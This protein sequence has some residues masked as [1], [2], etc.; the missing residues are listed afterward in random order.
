[1]P[2]MYRG[3]KL[4]P[5]PFVT[6]TKEFQR[7]ED[8]KV[9]KTFFNITATSKML[10]YKGGAD[11]QQ[12]GYPPDTD[13]VTAA[14]P[15]KRLALIIDKQKDMIDL[16]SV[17]GGWFEIQPYDGSAAIRFQPRIQNINFNEGLWF[18]Y[19]PYT[20]SMQA[21]CVAFG[22]YLDCGNNSNKQADETWSIEQADERGRT[23]RMT[24]QV[25][26][27]QKDK[28]KTD[29]SGQIELKGW[30]VAREMVL[31]RLGLVTEIKNA[32]KVL[33]LQNFNAY[34]YARSENIDE[35]A[36]RFSVT[37]TWLLVNRSENDCIEEY[38][39]TSRTSSDTGLT[40]V[41]IDGTVTGLE[42]RNN[43]TRALTTERYTTANLAFTGI[44]AQALSRCQNYSGVTLNPAPLNQSVGRQPL[45]GVITYNYEYNN[46]ASVIKGALNA[47]ITIADRFPADV[48]AKINVLERPLGPILQDIGSKTEAGRSLTIDLTM[49][50]AK[51]GMSDPEE[52]EVEDL[53][54]QYTP[55][56]TGKV[57]M[58]RTE[59]SWSPQTGRYSRN[60]SWTFN[61]E[62]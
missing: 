2:V 27:T 53:V 4:I 49:P 23:Y 33:D 20:I 59:K 28:Y 54:S 43:T 50:A 55:T 26:T 41:N 15:D 21:D 60:V 38:T 51:Y 14:D 57:F 45:N 40:S 19:F 11:W 7:G 16:F 5:A 6:I 48:F 32:A 36:G 12:S 1:M 58:D 52:P 56:G 61:K 46:R 10:A 44:I 62:T 37:E 24:H 35:A 18:E 31:V 47:S 9:Q 3:T 34:N 8:G 42:I 29:G 13:A 25:Q 17:D 39:V 30:Q 22:N